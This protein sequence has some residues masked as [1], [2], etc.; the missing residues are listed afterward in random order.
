MDESQLTSTNSPGH[1]RPDSLA[2]SVAVLLAANLIQR[3]IGFGR[4]VLFCRWLSPEEL[5]AWEMAYSFL[6]LAAPIIVLGL[7]GSFGRYLERYRQRNQLR[8]F[9]RRACAWTG[10][11]TAAAVALILAMA[12]QFS[13]LI[14]G[15]GDQ[16]SLVLFQ[17]H[18]YGFLQE[19]FLRQ[20][21]D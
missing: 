2:A 20:L 21:E 9:L 4:S 14:F 1:W 15:R 6:L 18:F 10:V 11:L 19:C 17:I 13:E 7:P 8:A 5:G 12:G 16:R 3:S